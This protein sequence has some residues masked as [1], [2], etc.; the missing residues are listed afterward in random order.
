MNA[1]LLAIV[2]AA[3]PLAACSAAPTGEPSG[4]SRSAATSAVYPDA[5]YDEGFD[6]D[7]GGASATADTAWNDAD[8]PQRPPNMPKS[9]LYVRETC[10][11]TACSNV[12]DLYAQPSYLSPRW[13][14]R[15][16]CIADPNDFQGGTNYSDIES[17]LGA[18]LPG[19]T[20]TG[21]GTPFDQAGADSPDF[22]WG[23]VTSL[24]D[25]HLPFVAGVSWDDVP[26][27]DTVGHVL[28]VV[29][30][31]VEGEL[32]YVLLMNFG[33]YKWWP[34][35]DQDTSKGQYGFH[36]R[37]RVND[38]GTT[39]YRIHADTPI[40]DDVWSHWHSP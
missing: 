12:Y 14:F 22:S 5:D 21:E 29:D 4:S 1:R 19:T 9:F 3:A 17:F 24:I 39:Y 32:R 30:Y 28:T 15:N 2:L 16:G 37:W 7:P 26:S 20:W 13:A 10:G 40:P 18:Q 25:R 27:K 36:T 23:I 38:G 34:W 35:T 11:P 33:H 8:D 6:L 31:K